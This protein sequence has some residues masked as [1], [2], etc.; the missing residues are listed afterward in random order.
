MTGKRN[1]RSIEALLD[2]LFDTLYGRPDGPLLP[3]RMALKP[4]PSASSYFVDAPRPVLDSAD[5]ARPAQSDPMIELE[6]VLADVPADVRREI[7][8]RLSA[9]YEALAVE[10]K[11]DSAEPPSLI[12]ALH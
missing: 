12:Y 4:D 5:M 1:S 3:S 6:R 9:L 11:D 8:T 7:I 10:A 2:D